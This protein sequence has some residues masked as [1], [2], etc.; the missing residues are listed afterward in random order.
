MGGCRKT[1]IFSLV[2][3]IAGIAVLL[4]VGLAA[5]DQ[6]PDTLVIGTISPAIAGQNIGVTVGGVACAKAVI[7]SGAPNGITD[8]TGAYALLLHNC[9][10]GRAML[11]VNGASTRTLFNLVPGTQLTENVPSSSFQISLPQLVRDNP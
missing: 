7:P 5:A 10:G 6:Q 9:P 2:S 4:P 11:T 8:A 3:A 1:L